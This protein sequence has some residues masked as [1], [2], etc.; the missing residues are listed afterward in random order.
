MLVIKN[1]LRVIGQ[2]VSVFILTYMCFAFFEYKIPGHNTHTDDDAVLMFFAYVI[3]LVFGIGLLINSMF[4]M[5]RNHWRLY[6]V[7]VLFYVMIISSTLLISRDFV[8]RSYLGK[9]KSEYMRAGGYFPDMIWTKLVLYE[10]N[11][12]LNTSSYGGEVTVETT[13]KYKLEN[14]S[15]SLSHMNKEELYIEKHYETLAKNIGAIYGIRNDT[16][17]CVD[18]GNKMKLIEKNN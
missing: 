4:Y 9:K 13:G 12:F 17:I 7:V 8:V 15:L 16:L 18:C 1:I 10:N 6:R 5:R 3:V 2:S 14:N 11:N